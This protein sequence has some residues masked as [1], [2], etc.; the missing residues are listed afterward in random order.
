MEWLSRFTDS[1]ISFDQHFSEFLQQYGMWS[2]LVLFLIIFAETGLVIAP[3]LPGDT[4]LFV[5]GVFALKEGNGLNIWLL[6]LV[7][8]IAAVMGNTANYHIA[9][10]FESKFLEKL[11]SPKIHKHL[12]GTHDLFEKYGGWAIIIARFVPFARTLAPF[13]AGIGRYSYGAFQLYNIL[14]AIL[15]VGACV[16]LGYFAGRVVEAHSFTKFIPVILIAAII[17][18]FLLKYGLGL[19]KSIKNQTPSSED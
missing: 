8:V 18:P 3:F 16:F 7:L 15:W 2:Y 9:R 17:L 1:I 11:K 6:F 13:V 14:G 19:I 10:L 5:A 4:L 12:K